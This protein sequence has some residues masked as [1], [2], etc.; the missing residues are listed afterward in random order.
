M[1][2]RLIY[3]LFY[4]I[5][6]RYTKYKHLQLTTLLDLFQSFN[7]SSCVHCF[8]NVVLQYGFSRACMGRA[9]DVAAL[10]STQFPQELAEQIIRHMNA[11]HIAGYVGLGGPYSYHYNRVHNLMTP[12]EMESISHLDM[13]SGSDAVKELVTWCN[14]DVGIVKRA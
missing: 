5:A 10:A 7:P 12:E 8:I 6:M 3:A 9:Q 13:H 1:K 4:M 11:A 2:S 14:R